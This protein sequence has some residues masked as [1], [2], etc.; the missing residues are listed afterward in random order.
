[1]LRRQGLRRGKEHCDIREILNAIETELEGSGNSIGYRQMHQRLRIDCGLI[2]QKETV[3]VIIKELDPAGEQSRS[4]K[5]LR[6]REYRGK[7]PNYIWHID[8]NDKLKAF[9]FC[10][11]G[12][13]N[14]YSRRILWLEVGRTKQQP[15]NHW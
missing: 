2:V 15:E 9:G 5:R 4:S 1:M 11:H 3:R 8:G 13:I 7:G 12:A 10:T 14:D 6:R